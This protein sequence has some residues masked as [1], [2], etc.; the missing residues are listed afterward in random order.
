MKSRFASAPCIRINISISQQITTT[1]KVITAVT[2]SSM[3]HCGQGRIARTVKP[4]TTYLL[5]R[6]TSTGLYHKN[7]VIIVPWC[8]CK[9]QQNLMKTV[10]GSVPMLLR[11]PYTSGNIVYGRLLSLFHIKSCVKTYRYLTLLS[12]TPSIARLTSFIGISSIQG[13]TPLSAAS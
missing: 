2:T 13:F 8:R 5:A 7:K 9:H 4:I 3:C 1:V 11:M 6:V 12:S 10:G